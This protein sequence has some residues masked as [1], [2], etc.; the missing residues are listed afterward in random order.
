MRL[1]PCAF[2]NEPSNEDIGRR[3]RNTESTAAG[4]F[5][6]GTHIEINP[7]SG[8]RLAL[9]PRSQPTR[10]TLFLEKIGY[11]RISVSGKT[12]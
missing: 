2:S 9:G 12:A 6:E 11:P 3:K 8:Y 7:A 5:Y 4:F 1:D 10:P